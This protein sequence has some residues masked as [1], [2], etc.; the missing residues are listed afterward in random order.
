MT[1][2]HDQETI[3][4]LRGLEVASVSD[5]LDALG[6]RDQVMNPTVRPLSAVPVAGRAFTWL[7]SS[8]V[9]AVGESYDRGIEAVDMLSAGDVVVV[10]TGECTVSASWGE[11][12]STRAA[13][14][15][16]MG[17]V[18]DGA[19]R[20]VAGIRNLGFPVFGAAVN[21]R[22]ARSRLTVVNYQIAVR[23]GGV[24]VAPGD[25]ILGEDD[26]VVVIPQGA[27]AEVIDRSERHLGLEV[28]VRE[29]LGSGRSARSA[30][31]EHNVL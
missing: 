5:A 1:L 12:L 16:A 3:T 17:A 27:V 10:A 25:Y 23:C 8:S 7:A 4:R 30:F 6:Y 11:L 26:G 22:D 13:A 19:V 9:V 2:A 28:V 24:V 14:L 20:D 29:Q 31:E 21:A 18:T 15:G